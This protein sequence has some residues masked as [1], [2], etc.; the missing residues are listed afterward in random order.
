LRLFRHPVAAALLVFL[1]VLLPL[2]AA[3]LFF[4]GLLVDQISGLM[5]K[6]P[7]W[8]DRARVEIQQ[9]LPQVLR[10]WHEHGLGERFRQ[11]LH[12][13]GDR[14]A[15]FVEALGGGVLTAGA[16]LFRS[17][18]GFLGWVVLPVYFFF[19]LTSKPIWRSSAES[20]LPFLKPE[21][22]KDIV[23][24]VTEFITIVVSFFRGQFIISLLQGVLYAVGFL[25][26]GLQFGVVIGLF[27]GL[28]N[29]I[30][31]VGSMAGLL[32]ALPT[33]FFQ[34]GGGLGRVAAAAGVIV[35]VQCIEGYL[36][37]PRIMGQR[38]GLHPMAIIFAIFFWGTALSGIMGMI[39]A[40]PLTAFLVVFW[41]L[42]K[43][44]YI[45]ELV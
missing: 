36:L 19:F 9:R 16:G 33:A 27:M 2:V 30:P 11:I 28:M 8:T 29:L 5:D 26:A 15:G 10:F 41:R 7:V 18:A 3:A 24:L 37:T 39:L 43:A 25:L 14:I 17:L 40:I 1:S 20:L 44:K 32:V 6:V 12:N 22:R 31:Y 38:T 21:T 4:G 35:A 34:D 45:K 23:Y 42:L 13:Q